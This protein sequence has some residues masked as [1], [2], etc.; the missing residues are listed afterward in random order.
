MADTSFFSFTLHYSGSE[1][2]PY[3]N[4]MSYFILD[5]TCDQRNVWDNPRYPE[6]LLVGETTT[7]TTSSSHIMR[8]GTYYLVV[9]SMHLPTQGDAFKLDVH[10]TEIPEVYLPLVLK[11][12]PPIPTVTA[13]PTSGPA[14]TEFHLNGSNFT[15]GETVSHWMTGPGGTPIQL[16]PSTFSA[17]S[18]GRFGWLFN[19]TSWPTGIY[20]YYALGDQ[21]QHEA[22][23]TFEITTGS[24][25][26]SLLPF[27]SFSPR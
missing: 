18:Q 8:P 14:G 13:D 15:P 1:T 10:C 20:T 3:N 16:T 9:D 5:N 7:K 17:N 12:Y 23:V 21:S 6:P 2:L 24:P 26:L 11:D 4:Y 22:S 25:D 19:T 27:P